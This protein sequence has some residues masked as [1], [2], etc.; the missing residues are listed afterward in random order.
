MVAT[1]VPTVG[2]RQWTSL[3]GYANPRK[4][5]ASSPAAPKSVTPDTA[6]SLHGTRCP[7]Y[8]R[9]GWTSLRLHS[10]EQAHSVVHADQSVRKGS[11]LQQRAQGGSVCGERGPAPLA[12][13]VIGVLS[14]QQHLAFI[15]GIDG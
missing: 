13:R 11:I 6:E 15:V 14:E 7:A 12:F 4:G 10:P 1:S 2:K 9:S 5:T 8:G 3:C